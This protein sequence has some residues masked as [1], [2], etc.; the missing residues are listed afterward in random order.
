MKSPWSRPFP[1]PTP[2]PPRIK[3]QAA[4][5]GARCD[6]PLLITNQLGI[7]APPNRFAKQ[8]EIGGRSL[9]PQILFTSK[10]T[11]SC[12]QVHMM[13]TYEIT[14][15]LRPGAGQQLC[16]SARLGDGFWAPSRAAALG[17]ER[18]GPVG[19]QAQDV[20]RDQS[21]W[22]QGAHA[23]LSAHCLASPR[24][25]SWCFSRSSKLCSGLD[26]NSWM[27]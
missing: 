12:F 7:S 23:A 21:Y 9:E 25:G 22:G 26:P 2:K 11:F 13:K 14:A 5:T 1:T 20:A 4:A 10:K 18:W 24:P 3:P 15:P 17:R 16:H 27:N 19:L 8:S 6:A